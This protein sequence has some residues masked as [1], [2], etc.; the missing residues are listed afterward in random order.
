MSLKEQ[1]KPLSVIRNCRMEA[2]H[3]LQIEAYFGFL[4]FKDGFYTNSQ[5]WAIHA[6]LLYDMW[7]NGELGGE[8]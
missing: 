6:A 3:Y 7:I 5:G 1:L 8:S 2:G 4:G